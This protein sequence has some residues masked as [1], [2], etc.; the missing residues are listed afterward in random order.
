MQDGG[1]KELEVG[2][3]RRGSIL[4]L[5]PLVSFTH[6]GL[7]CPCDCKRFAE[8]AV[9]FWA[10]GV[11]WL[12]HHVDRYYRKRQPKWWIMEN[13]LAGDTAH[14]FMIK[15]LTQVLP[16]LL[17]FPTLFLFVLSLCMRPLA[18]DSDTVRCYSRIDSR[19][20]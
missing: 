12:I 13:F 17:Q 1:L 14:M 19:G 9:V 3:Q 20:A 15:A 11:P 10:W 7:L 18:L 4:H 8:K 6:R 5:S 16:H 2:G